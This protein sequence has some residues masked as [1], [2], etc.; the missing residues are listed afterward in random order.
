MIIILYLLQAFVIYGLLF[1]DLNYE[2]NPMFL[3]IQKKSRRHDMGMAIMNACILG[4]IPVLGIFIALCLSG[5]AEH[6]W[7]LK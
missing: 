4:I 5:F 2:D 6:G 7:R 1:A 3:E